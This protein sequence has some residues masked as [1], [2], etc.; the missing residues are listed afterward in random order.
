MKFLYKY[1]ITYFNNLDIKE[2]NDNERFRK[3]FIP[4]FPKKFSRNEKINLTKE[5]EMIS[6]D[7]ESELK[8]AFSTFFSKAVEGL[9]NLSI[10]K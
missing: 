4:L 6:T 7:S 1:L 8:Q 3:T 9:K 10:C 2:V 5:N